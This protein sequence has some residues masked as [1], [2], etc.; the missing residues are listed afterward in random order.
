VSQITKSLEIGKLNLDKAKAFLLEN[1]ASVL[2]DK[3]PYMYKK[4]KM[5]SVIVSMYSSGKVVVQGNE[6]GAVSSIESRILSGGDGEQVSKGKKNLLSNKPTILKKTVSLQN[7]NVIFVE[8]MIGADETG[9]GEYFGPLVTGACF[10]PKQYADEIISAGICDS[11]K[12]KNEKI[13]EYEKLIKDRCVCAVTRVNNSDFN[14]QMRETGNISEV[15]ASAHVKSITEVI[16]A[17]SKK[18]KTQ[19]EEI[20]QILIDKF[21]KIESRVHS[22]FKIDIPVIMEE[23]GEKY[24]SVA[25]ASVIARAEYLRAWAEIESKYGKLPKGYQGLTHFVNGFINQYGKEAWDEI[26]KTSYS[27]GK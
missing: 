6:E 8:G 26:A 4:L 22:K 7:S 19:N 25:C 12:I 24:L 18:Q 15:L 16:E 1:G 14:L 9:K 23:K 2:A 13:F 5:G 3:N 17:Q 21:T 20:T 27:T 10:V 11:K